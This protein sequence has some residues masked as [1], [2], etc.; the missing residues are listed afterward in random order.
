M[1]GSRP[2]QHELEGNLIA[3]SA[4]ASQRVEIGNHQVTWH[5]PPGL[6]EMT[7]STSGRF[8][9]IVATPRAVT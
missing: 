5:R 3:A 6:E 9:A 8:S 2:V 7:F 4:E 1:S